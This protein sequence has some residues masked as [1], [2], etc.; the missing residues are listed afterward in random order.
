M[1]EGIWI[2]VGSI[3]VG[4]AL[5]LFT[6]RQHAWFTA[7]RTFAVTAVA[8]VVAVQMLPE[9]V[10]ELGW[11]AL[12]V[13]VGALALP[14]LVAPLV[15]RLSQTRG[16]V[17]RHWIG[18]ELGFVG[19]LLHQVAE[20][21]AMG[22]YGGSDHAYAS[23]NSLYFAVAAHTVPLAALLTVEALIHRGRGSALRRSSLLVLATLVGFGLADLAQ[24]RLP[25]EIHP[26]LAAGVAGFLVHV[27][28]HDHDAPPKRTRVTS[29][30]DVL[31]ALAGV[32]LPL[33]AGQFSHSD[34]GPTRDAFL[35]AFA[36]LMAETAPMLLLG[37]FLGAALQLV[38]AK[39]PSRFFRSGG[40]LRQALRGV[41]VGAPLPLCACGVLPLAESLRKRG[42][43]PALVLAFLIATPE[44]GPET[45]VLTA[46]FMGWPFAIFRVGAA[47]G[48]AVLAGYAFAKIVG[49][50]GDR[51]LDEAAVP[52]AVRGGETWALLRRGYGY[53]D[54]LVLHT[55]PWTV[56][57]LLAAA[58]VQI[59]LPAD[60]LGGLRDGGLDIWVVAVVA[61][62]TYVCAASATPLAAVLLVKGVSPGAVLAGLLL[63]PATNIATVGV[64]RRAYGNRAVILGVGL[65]LLASV[66][67][68]YAVNL[69][70]LPVEL[71]E[72]ML[73]EHAHGWWA[74]AS[75]VLLGLVLVAQL[76]RRGTR[77]WLEVLGGGHD[78]GHGHGHD[79]GHGHGHGHGHDHGHAHDD[80][81][82]AQRPER[83]HEHDGS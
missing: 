42:A 30:L 23:T 24:H 53:F 50:R 43:G 16:G 31:A 17:S 12:V 63:G 22:T 61:M 9:A 10:G 58:Y 64:L 33:V 76:W 66:G 72:S 36:E 3:V 27:I 38:G 55:A 82:E 71:S 46:R 57:G 32:A 62:P 48:L 13:F 41:A 37:L 20:G 2:A 70:S 21:L 5:G 14:S 47:V 11:L 49:K 18:A 29:S 59:A 25:H 73:G 75:I 52:S 15:R 80:R 39:I 19:F 81:H 8:S 69:S 65:V 51:R 28:F 6:R 83:D 77:P 26:V 79:H 34:A 1:S 60:S 40:S 7:L 45:L 54:E 4:S 74:I 56:V 35:A 78:H 67:L 68:G 44:L